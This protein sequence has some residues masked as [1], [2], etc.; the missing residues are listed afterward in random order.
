MVLS[1]VIIVILI[2]IYVY[3]EAQG[4]NNNNKKK[5]RHEILPHFR[6]DFAQKFSCKSVSKILFLN[7]INTK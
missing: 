4:N 2:L 6:A 5:K 1:S 7:Y 3:D